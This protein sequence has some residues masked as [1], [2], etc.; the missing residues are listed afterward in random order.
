[1][2]GRR[3]TEEVPWHLRPLW[4][5]LALVILCVVWG[6]YGKSRLFGQTIKAKLARQAAS[7]TCAL[8][9]GRDLTR[10]SW[11]RYCTRRSLSPDYFHRAAAALSDGYVYL[12]FVRSNSPAG[13][14][15]GLFTERP[16][17]HVSLALDRDLTTLV[18]Y[19]GGGPGEAPGLNPETLAELVHRQGACVRLYRLP[20]TRE[21]KR[22]ILRRL[23][24]IDQEGSAYNLLGLL[25]PY[26]AQPNTMFCSQFVYGILKLAGLAYFQKDPLQVRP[27]DLL[28]WDLQGRLEFLR[29]YAHETVLEWAHC[30]HTLPMVCSGAEHAV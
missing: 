27:T 26:A 19:N 5:L 24:K 25:L 30:S 14:V 15:I 13:Q 29:E 20:A 16:Y 3:K 8:A 28:E 23:G 12:A 7:P 21:Q 17:N 2:A 4:G 9:L 22:I 10:H 18:S 11:F 1:M 6:I